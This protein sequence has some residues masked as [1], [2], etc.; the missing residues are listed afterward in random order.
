M[1]LG[2]GAADGCCG[3]LHALVECNN[4]VHTVLI[5][6]TMDESSPWI[7]RFDS[8]TSANVVS[9]VAAA[10]ALECCTDA[11]TFVQLQLLLCSTHRLETKH[12]ES[13]TGVALPSLMSCLT[14]TL[15]LV[16]GPDPGAWASSRNWQSRF[17]ATLT[18]LACCC[19][20]ARYPL[21]LRWMGY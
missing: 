6:P 16:L 9:K 10:S 20:S 19:L 21:P 13:A 17:G 5:E 3:R 4:L 1:R 12:H 7:E 11:A 15:A 8:A 2:G 18:W 14:L